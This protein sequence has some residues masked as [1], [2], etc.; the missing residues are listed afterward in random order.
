[1]SIPDTLLL[2]GSNINERS[3]DKNGTTVLMEE[4]MKYNLYTVNYLLDKGA[5]LTI[6]CVDLRET[7]FE[8]AEKLVNIT[9]EACLLDRCTK[10]SSFTT[11][12]L[13]NYSTPTTTA[14]LQVKK[15]HVILEHLIHLSHLQKNHIFYIYVHA[16]KIKSLQYLY[17][18][19]F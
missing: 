3:C 4:A 1:M 14:D 5:D 11:I 12:V 16:L 8:K 13:D 19:I 15:N 2:Y 6:K 18:R 7:A 9:I 10:R 17:K